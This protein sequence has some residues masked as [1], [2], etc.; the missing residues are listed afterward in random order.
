MGATEP[1]PAVRWYGSFYVRI[2]F[3][4]VVF[5]DQVLAD[6]ERLEQVI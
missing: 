6:P 1:M 4:F 5:A 2:G 3:V